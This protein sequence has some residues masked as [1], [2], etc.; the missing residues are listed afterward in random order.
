ML[1]KL[2]SPLKISF[3]SGNILSPTFSAENGNEIWIQHFT[4]W[5][6]ISNYF[7]IF[8][9]QWSNFIFNSSFRSNVWI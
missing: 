8:I 2:E 9:F 7:P 5:S 3:T 1:I 6:I 4:H